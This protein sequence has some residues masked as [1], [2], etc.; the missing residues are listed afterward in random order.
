MALDG[1]NHINQAH[2]MV[3]RVFTG[4]CKDSEEPLKLG[5]NLFRFPNTITILLIFLE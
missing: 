2:P 4:G 1:N 3:A 5:N